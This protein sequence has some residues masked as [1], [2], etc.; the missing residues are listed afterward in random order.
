VTSDSRRL[1]IL[2]RAD[3]REPSLDTID[4]VVLRALEEDCA[5][6][7]RSTLPLPGIDRRRRGRVLARERGVLAGRAVFRRAFELLDESGSV[8]LEGLED[9]ESFGPGSTVLAVEAPSGVLLSGERTA[10]NFLQR[11][12]GIATKTRQ[13]VE[14]AGARVAISD[15]R[16]TTPL[17]RALEKYAV[18]AG[19]GTSHRW[20]LA[21][22]VMIK[23]NHIAV[24]GGIARAVEA[25]RQDP[26]SS[27]CPV[28]VEVKSFTEAMLAADLS[29]NRLLLD[30][31][32]PEAMSEVVRALRGR[33]DCPE[34]EASGGVTLETISAISRTGVDVVSVGSLTHSSRAIDFSFLVEAGPP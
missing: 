33:A 31:M 28:T 6:D 2:G 26:K 32:T 11:L 13:M 25:V 19:G 16:K 8:A 15:T 24:A 27:S 20:S 22:V 9:G 21:D 23:E 30:N 34:L 12:S 1:P 14:A 7:D 4:D 29:V 3:A 18:V 5:F 10:L 17:L